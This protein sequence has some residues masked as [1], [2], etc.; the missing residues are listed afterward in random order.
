[1]APTSGP[2]DAD[3]V[4][5]EVVVLSAGRLMTARGTLAEVEAGVDASGRGGVS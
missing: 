1:M 5:I 4:C 2:G 3:V